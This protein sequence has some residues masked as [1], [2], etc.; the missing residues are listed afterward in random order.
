LQRLNSL[1]VSGK[2]INM[3]QRIQTIW[4]LLAVIAAFLTLKFNSVV[5]EDL[6]RQYTP[7]N[8]LNSGTAVLIITILIGLIAFITMFLYKNR[9]VQL[10]LCIAGILLQLVLVFL[11]YKK[12]STFTSHSITI[13]VLLH[14]AVI[15]GFIFAASG[16]NKDEKLIKDSNRL[17]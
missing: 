3:L 12:A 14:L 5:A 8:A 16:I 6:N 2:K 7:L 15:V 13:A 11:Y 10:R 17:R 1:I 9:P 4:L